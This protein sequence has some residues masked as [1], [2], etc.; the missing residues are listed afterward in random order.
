MTDKYEN[1]DEEYDDEE[2]TSESEEEYEDEAEDAEASDE[3]EEVSEGEESVES[4]G[5][6]EKKSRFS[7]EMLAGFAAIGVLVAIFGIVVYKKM[8]GSGDSNEVAV[9]PDASLGNPE[10]SLGTPEDSGTSPEDDLNDPFR[11]GAENGIAASNPGSQ[12]EPGGAEASNTAPGGGEFVA[13]SPANDGSTTFEPGGMLS[14]TVARSPSEGSSGQGISSDPFGSG[15]TLGNDEP[16]ASNAA[17]TD[18]FSGQSEPGLGSNEEPPFGGST[19]GTSTATD[20]FGQPLAS[21]EFSSGQPDSTKVFPG[22]GRNDFADSTRRDPFG[23]PDL[24]GSPSTDSGS[25][26]FGTNE[27]NGSGPFS[28]DKQVAKNE[29]NIDRSLNSSLSGNSGSAFPSETSGNASEFS[30][31]TGSEPFGTTVDN[32]GSLTNDSLTTAPFGSSVESVSSQPTGLFD[33]GP[34]TSLSGGGL[35]E[36]SPTDLSASSGF[37]NDT[38]PDNEL[39]TPQPSTAESEFGSLN[40]GSAI[41]S[42]AP[43]GSGEPFGT[44]SNELAESPLGNSGTTSPS[45]SNDPFG[46]PASTA[47]NDLFPDSTSRPSSGLPSTGFDSGNELESESSEPVDLFPDTNSLPLDTA[48]SDPFQPPLTSSPASS[49]PGASSSISSDPSGNQPLR[50]GSSTRNQTFASEPANS[51]TYTVQEGDS[52]WNISKKVYGTAKYFQV[53]ADHNRKTIADP[54]KMKTGAVIQ[55]PDAAVLQA[56]LK[57]VPRPSPTALS[58]RIET[59]GRAD[60]SGSAGSASSASESVVVSRRETKSSEPSGILFNEQGY[61]MFKIGE[62]DTLTSI[63]SDHLGRASRWQQIYNMNRDQLQS[64]DKL[65]IG[66]L[67]KLPADASRVP[68]IDRTSSLR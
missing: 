28:Q 22:S 32:S 31:S 15:G 10:S 61:P 44:S 14:S 62:T 58:G 12:F 40:S 38:L 30:S 67:L 1:E 55:T 46:S 2:A 37:G 47:S 68:L 53:L 39:G 49:S 41:D 3:S 9:A 56:R 63:A 48:S 57:T 65:Q 5:Y 50:S 20:A 25:T 26:V 13:L 16:F 8:P 33:R 51:G 4:W 45:M 29:P 60:R 52:Y 54:E 21:N 24:A 64:P 43:F 59:S 19:V 23:G 34:E 27:G 36:P 18:L 6:E 42:S 7:K 35:N 66:M 11:A 17:T